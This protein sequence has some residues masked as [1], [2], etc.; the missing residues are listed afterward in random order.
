[1]ARTGLT[2]G[3]MIRYISSGLQITFKLVPLCVVSTLIIGFIIGIIQFRKIPVLS[4]IID[5]YIQIMRGV[6]PLIIIYLVYCNSYLPSFVIAFLALT[7]YHSAYIA[8]IVR[9]GFNG[10]PNGQM[11]A[12]ESLGLRYFTIMSRI[13]TPQVLRQIVPSLC[14]QYILLV[15]DTTLVSVVGVQDIMWR[16]RQIMEH[17]FQPVMVYILIGVMFYI[18]CTIIELIGKA[19]ERR[20][21]KQ[22]VMQRRKVTQS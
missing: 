6:P 16:A 11:Q 3:Q 12:G 14:G 2:L 10:I 20:L 8:E 17:S 21:K 1:M 9:G 13:Y 15:K 18:L 4:R 7:M 22:R 5:I 19:A